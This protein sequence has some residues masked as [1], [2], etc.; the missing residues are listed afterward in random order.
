MSLKRLVLIAVVIVVGLGLVVQ[1]GQSAQA[2]PPNM[3]F[4]APATVTTC[5]ANSITMSYTVVHDYT[6]PGTGLSIQSRG[7]IGGVVV[8]DEGTIAPL[9]SGAPTSYA[10]TFAFPFSAAQPNATYTY[11]HTWVSILNGVA[12]YTSRLS[13][14]CNW[15]GGAF[16]PGGATITNLAGGSAFEGPPIPAGFV[17]LTVTCNVAAVQSPGGPVVPNIKPLVP[18]ATWFMSPKPVKDAKGKLWT[19]VFLGGWNNAYI[20]AECAR[21]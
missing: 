5:D 7:T 2:A 19:E 12:V 8:Y 10:H 13:G 9:A 11:T 3:H 21:W 4:G 15:T 14:T 1:P 18:G 17:L 16:S 20:P 6:S